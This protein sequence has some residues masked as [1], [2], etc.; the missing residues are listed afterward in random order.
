MITLKLALRSL[1]NRRF[2]AALTVM[3]IA[4]SVSLLLGVDK[5]RES[6]RESFTQTVSGTDLIVGARSGPIQLLLYA[7]FR[8]GDATNNVSW[9]SYQKI[10]AHRQVAWAIPLSLGD[11]HRG[12]RVL[13]TTG[14]YFEHLRYRQNRALEFADGK[15]FAD[16]YDAVIGADVARELNYQLGQKIIIA[17]GAAVVNLQQHDDKPF[18]VVGILKPTG[19]PVDRTVHVSLQAIEAI[20][21]DWRGGTRAPG[22]YAIDAEQAREKDLE[23]KAITAFYLGLKSKIA[24]FMIQRGINEFSEEPLLAILPAV[25]L[26]QLWSLLGVAEKALLVIAAFVVLTGLLGMLSAILTTLNERRREMAILRSVGA[27]PHHIFA[28]MISEAGA[29]ALLGVALGVA[30]TYAL[31]AIAQPL[32]EARAGIFIT[33]SALSQSQWLILLSIVISALLIGAIPAWLAYRRSLSDGMTIR[34]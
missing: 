27:R 31:I 6:A 8:I 34:T 28:L 12:F 19:T 5:I 33:L 1:W 17:H 9:E 22:Q 29:L 32:L 16:L 25:A 14:A 24:T 11:S 15:P 3:T 2:T 7:V 21:I 10:T 30:L 23:P 26:Q 18:S 13:G 4:L 20:H